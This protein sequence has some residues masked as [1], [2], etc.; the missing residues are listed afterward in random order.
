MHSSYWYKDKTFSKLA[1]WRDTMKQLDRWREA[2]RRNGRRKEGRK[3][4]RKVVNFT[5]RLSDERYSSWLLRLR[6]EPPLITFSSAPP[7]THRILTAGP[8]SPSIPIP[9]SP[10]LTAACHLPYGES[11]PDVTHNDATSSSKLLRRRFVWYRVGPHRINQVLFFFLLSESL[12]DL[13]G[14]AKTGHW[15]LWVKNVPH[16]S[17]CT[18]T[19]LWWDH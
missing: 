6:H 4:G 18:A 9:P 13:Q 11:F 2:G 15:C 16:I 3:E 1:N 8:R 14:G 7:S 17:Q 19:Q 10:L 12:S 5:V